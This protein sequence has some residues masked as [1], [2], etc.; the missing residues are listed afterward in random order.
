MSGLFRAATVRE[1]WLHVPLAAIVLAVLFGVALLQA[2]TA[3]PNEQEQ[4][5]LSKAIAEAGTSPVDFTRALE[6]HLQK[7]PQARQRA[8]IEKALAKSAIE[9]ND[10]ARIVLYGEKVLASEPKSD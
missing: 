10:R 9:A 6:R 5:D 7:Y 2:Q 4:L 8:A 3:E 1:R